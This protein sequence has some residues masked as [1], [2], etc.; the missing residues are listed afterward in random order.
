M[1]GVKIRR[2]MTM[3]VF[4]GIL[5][6]FGVGTVVAVAMP[7]LEKTVSFSAAQLSS[8]SLIHI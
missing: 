2:I 5:Y 4:S 3:S 8:L 1:N 6:G 7:Y